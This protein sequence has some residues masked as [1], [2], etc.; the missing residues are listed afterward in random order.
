MGTRN[1]TR[2]ILNGRVRVSQYG[3]WDGYP[4]CTGKK[5]LEFIRDTDMT[6]F[7]ER[8]AKT[9]FT[10]V[11]NEEHLSYTSAPYLDD[12]FQLYDETLFGGDCSDPIEERKALAKAR[13][14]KEYGEDGYVKFLVA[15]RDTGADIL[16]VI[17]NFRYITFYA[18]E[19]LLGGTDWQIEAVNEIDLDKEEVRM[20]WHGVK[21]T[22]TFS[23]IPNMDIDKEMEEYEEEEESE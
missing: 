21:K 6:E 2:V 11:G 19:Y 5:I 16:D 18:S 3:Q 17:M 1:I 13:I 4:T 10:L 8:V 9:N 23:D 14:I 22:V 7:K 12:I 20:D 15:S